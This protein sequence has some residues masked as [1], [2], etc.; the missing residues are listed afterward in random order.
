[1]P[2]AIYLWW[3]GTG[4]IALQ[5]F[6][7]SPHAARL[8]RHRRGACL[9]RLAVPRGELWRPHPPSRPRRP[10]PA[11]DISAVAGDLLHIVDVLWLGRL[12][13]AHRLRIPHHLYRP[14][15]CLLYTSPSPRDGLLSR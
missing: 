12:G 3:R 6:F 4:K 2:R 10:H 15:A 14:G 8:G 7:W 13:V 11:D 9:Y 1:M 5:D